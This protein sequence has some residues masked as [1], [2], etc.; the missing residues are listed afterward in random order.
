[1]DHQSPI[2]RMPSR[3]RT[4]DDTRSPCTESDEDLESGNGQRPN[5]T[6]QLQR[7]RERSPSGRTARRRNPGREASVPELQTPG[8][9]HGCAP[10]LWTRQT[11]GEGEQA[12]S[13]STAEVL[14]VWGSNLMGAGSC[15]STRC[16]VASIYLAKRRG[17]HHK[18]DTWLEWAWL[19]RE[20][21]GIRRQAARRGPAGL[22]ATSI[23]T[24]CY[25]KISIIVVPFRGV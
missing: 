17:L 6:R 2:S 25:L 18:I 12:A 7:G 5:P 3:M 14:L 9:E 8:G 15:S 13:E 16:S 23:C 4:C 22:S 24:A 20:H 19:R 11:L 10:G 21:D 1:M